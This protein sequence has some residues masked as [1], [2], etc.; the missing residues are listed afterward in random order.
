MLGNTK[1]TKPKSIWVD[2]INL[3]NTYRPMIFIHLLFMYLIKQSRCFQ[4]RV[5]SRTFTRRAAGGAGARRGVRARCAPPR[6]CAGACRCWRGCRTTRSA[7]GWQTVSLVST[8]TTHNNLY[9]PRPLLKRVSA[10]LAAKLLA[11]N[12]F[13]ICF[14]Q[15]W[16]RLPATD[17]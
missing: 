16:H 12:H 13:N 1:N 4:S 7:A 17:S 14:R 11:A 10:G 15:A 5:R 2:W 6:R 8:P 3:C 9:P